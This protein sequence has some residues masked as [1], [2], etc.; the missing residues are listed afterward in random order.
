MR[1]IPKMIIATYKCANSDSLA[2]ISIKTNKTDAPT[3]GT[4]IVYF[5]VGYQLH[6]LTTWCTRNCASWKGVEESFY[7]IC[8]LI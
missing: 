2:Y 1:L 8:A 7:L 3:V 5:D 6:C 4:T